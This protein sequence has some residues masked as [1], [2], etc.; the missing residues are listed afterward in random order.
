M[1][2]DRLNKFTMSME[3]KYIN[4]Y[5]NK[6]TDEINS[7]DDTELIKLI[8]LYDIK[9]IIPGKG[10]IPFV[11]KYRKLYINRLLPA[12]FAKEKFSENCNQKELVMAF[13]ILLDFWNIAEAKLNN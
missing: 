8:Q 9:I 13:K 10:Y 3:D 4:D 12:I 7:M 2:W 6:I 5:K 11:S 1:I